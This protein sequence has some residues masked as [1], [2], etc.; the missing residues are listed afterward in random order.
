MAERHRGTLVRINVRE[1]EV[2]DGH[3]SLGM[4]ALA[5]LTAIDRLVG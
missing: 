4:G 2:P 3:I 1:P 5:A